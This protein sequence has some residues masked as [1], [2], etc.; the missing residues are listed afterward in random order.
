[1][2]RPRDNPAWYHSKACF[3]LFNFTIEWVVVALYA[4]IRVDK[5]FIVP[6]K[7]KGPG[8]YSRKV[9]NESD[10]KTND[11]PGGIL[12]RVLSEEEVFDGEV[13]EEDKRSHSDT[14]VEAQHESATR[15]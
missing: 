10:E 14:D 9:E 12:N 1:M 4:I 5:R 2:P 11:Q 7:S 15:I 3:Y 13:P 6:N 8:D